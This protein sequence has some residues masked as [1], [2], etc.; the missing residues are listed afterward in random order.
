VPEDILAGFV[1]KVRTAI[2]S[3]VDFVLAIAGAGAAGAV[4]EVVKSWFPEQTATMGDEAIAAAVGFVLFY[5]GDRIHRLLV[6][7]GLGVFLAAIG[8][9]SSEWVGSI[10]LMLKKAA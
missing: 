10:I 7:F 1:A 2:T 9:W 5:W 4:A 8:A 3:T 6:P